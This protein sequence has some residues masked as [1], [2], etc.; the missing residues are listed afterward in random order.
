[1]RRPGPWKTLSVLV[2]TAAVAGCG[3]T[4]PSGSTP[5]TSPAS[6]Q[7]SATAAG[8][9]V[10]TAT[11][12]PTDGA[13]T[14]PT[15]PA[16]PT[17]TAKPTKAPMPTPTPQ[18]VRAHWDTLGFVAP[19]AVAGTTAVRLGGG[20]I[21]F[22]A[23]RDGDQ[24]YASVWSPV[25]G[26]VRV[27]TPLNAP[28]TEFVAVPLRDGRAMVIG[29]TNDVDQSYSSTYIFDAAGGGSWT[30][31][32]LL[33]QARSAP[34]AAVLR[35]GRV[36]VAGGYFHVKPDW[37]SIA[38][39]AT[40]AIARPGGS[41]AGPPPLNDVAPPFI[42]AAMA[43]AELFDPTTGTWS[44][45]GAMR[46][47]RA[48]CQAVSLADGRVL[49][50]GSGG[51]WDGVGIDER[52]LD[53]AEIYDPKTGRFSPAGQLPELSRSTSRALHDAGT[54]GGEGGSL[55][56]LENGGAVLI[57]VGYYWKHQG[58]ATRSFRYSPARNAWVEIGQTWAV[59]FDDP[60]RKP[61]VVT[62]GVRNLAGAAAALLPDG[63]VL[64]AGGL[65]APTA[66]DNYAYDSLP[67]AAVLAYN[68]ANGR[69]SRLPSM[70]RARA[71]GSAVVQADGSV[72]IAGGSGDDEGTAL[73]SFVRYTPPR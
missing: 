59:Y 56:A 8:G 67:V 44:K 7:P 68:P 72:V 23:Q 1:M 57:G 31:T 36:L 69:W 28:R 39:P 25:K 3:G 43:T 70:P 41:D 42:G 18:H 24:R 60:G 13:T 38:L 45:T 15:G 46:Y 2:L 53:T 12:A 6:S 62:R 64:V 14:A 21:L 66:T 30:K 11:T 32:G 20:R 71:G 33:H 27:T 49:V 5:A 16:T 54:T 34:C 65:S 58:E 19:M 63:R 50:V 52:A 55:V 73:R 40:L 10:P 4:L 51:A 9:V 29:G 17:A 48:R 26:D 35:D 61:T 47:A 37:G 22:L